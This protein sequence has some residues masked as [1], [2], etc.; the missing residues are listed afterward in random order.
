MLSLKIKDSNNLFKKNQ[1]TNPNNNKK[2]IHELQYQ[3][4][5]C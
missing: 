1:K 2:T 5:L 4:V 3:L